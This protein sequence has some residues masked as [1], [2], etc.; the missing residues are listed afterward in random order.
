M[1]T[2]KKELLTYPLPDM[3]RV[4][5][6][7]STSVLMRTVIHYLGAHQFDQKR[8]TTTGYQ[9]DQKRITTI[10][11]ERDN[12]AAVTAPFRCHSVDGS[13]EILKWNFSLNELTRTA[14]HTLHQSFKALPW[15]TESQ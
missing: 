3:Y 7:R 13:C 1:G 5:D 6:K 14:N 10:G 15:V 8:I 12:T 4:N 2:E 9:S 11:P